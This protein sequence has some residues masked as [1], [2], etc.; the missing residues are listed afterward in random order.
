MVNHLKNLHSEIAEME[1]K[2]K[3]RIVGPGR[4]LKNCDK[5][6]TKL[7]EDLLRVTIFDGPA[8]IATTIVEPGLIISYCGGSQL[9]HKRRAQLVKELGL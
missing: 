4:T 2:L 3:K 1:E 5:I 8:H 7:D 9:T 6:V